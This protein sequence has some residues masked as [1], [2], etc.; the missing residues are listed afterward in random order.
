MALNKNLDLT[1]LF[2]RVLI[3]HKKSVPFSFS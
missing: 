2:V 1:H 3:L